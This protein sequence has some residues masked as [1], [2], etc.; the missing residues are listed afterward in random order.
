MH[1]HT[2]TPAHEKR[3]RSSSNK[4][5]KNRRAETTMGDECDQFRTHVIQHLRPNTDLSLS[6][7]PLDLDARIGFVMHVGADP[8]LAADRVRLTAERYHKCGVRG[9]D[10]RYADEDAGESG[11]EP[12]Q[13]LYYIAFSLYDPPNNRRRR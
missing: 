12:L 5:Q 7:R 11:G 1:T 6:E 2:H 4:I 13:N 9:L 3:R 8:A 10:V